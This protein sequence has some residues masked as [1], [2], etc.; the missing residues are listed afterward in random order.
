ML[1]KWDDLPECMKT[2][3]VRVYYDILA[4]KKIS[5]FLKRVFDILASGI[6]LILCLPVFIVTAVAIKL[7]SK[8]PVFYRQVRVTRYNEKF[9]IFKFRSMVNDA[10]KGSKLTTGNDS[11][12]TKVGRFIRKYK[13]DELCQLIDVFR[14]KM[15][16]VGTRPEV[17]QYVNKYTDAMMATL[18]LPAGITSEASVYYLNENALLDSSED[19]EKTYLEVVLPDKMYYNLRAIKKFSIFHDIKIILVTIRSVFREESPE[20]E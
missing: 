5:L 3:E 10:D 8:G 1:R 15:T 19:V 14:G 18:L 13:I 7:D 12:V 20:R 17:P 16:F 9:R 11:R 6:L 2:P 4:K